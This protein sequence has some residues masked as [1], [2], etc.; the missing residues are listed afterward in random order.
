VIHY[1]FLRR[2]FARAWLITLVMVTAIGASG[3][4]AGAAPSKVPAQGGSAQTIKIGALPD[5]DPAKLQRLYGTVASYLQA[6]LGIKA[7]YVPVTDNAALVSLFRRG[8]LDVVWF[9][10]LTGVQA[11]IQTPGSKPIVQ[12]DIDS[13]FHSIFI[14]NASTS[15]KAFTDVKGL[16]AMKGKRFTFGAETST[17]GRLMPQYFLDKAGVQPTDF[18]G[19]AGFSGS[20]DK[21][22]DLVQ[23]GT[24]EAGAVNEQV[25]IARVAAGTVDT[26][27]VIAVYRTPEYYDYQ[28][29]VRGD[30]E[31]KF[32][33]GFTKKLTDT[34]LGL[35]SVDPDGARILSLFG[36]T[37]FTPTK[38]SNYKQIEAVGKKL[39]LIVKTT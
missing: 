2:A 15:V 34:F 3:L 17:S 11:R 14:V 6:Q 38:A 36:A 4:S 30:A 37:S 31:K 22:I 5:Q 12:R 24:Y 35:T 33:K 20:H 25:W 9:G 23:S 10:G 18:S 21:T 28:W 8:D 7:E 13:H 32:G 16:S 1:A 27:K 19:Q 39:G 26:S 29:D